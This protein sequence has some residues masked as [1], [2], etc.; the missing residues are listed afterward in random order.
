MSFLLFLGFQQATRRAGIVPARGRLP[1]TQKSGVEFDNSTP[2]DKSERNTS[3]PLAHA[4]LEKRGWHRYNGN[5]VQPLAVVL[6][7]TDTLHRGIA[8]W[9]LLCSAANLR[10]QID[11]NP[12]PQENQGSRG[13]FFTL[14]RA[15]AG[16]LAKVT[17]LSQTQILFP[18]NQGKAAEIRRKNIGTET[19]REKTQLL[20]VTFR[21]GVPHGRINT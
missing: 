12:L 14:P 4:A 18:E 7:G 16:Y 8:G 2:P 11:F 3:N 1:E 10:F 13:K 20:S 17:L 5:V 21:G 6:S 19:I 9:N 15:A